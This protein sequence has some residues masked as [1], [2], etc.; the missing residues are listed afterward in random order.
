[1]KSHENW[2][3]FQS[4]NDP[5]FFCNWEDKFF[6]GSINANDIGYAIQFNQK[7]LI[8]LA[9]TNKESYKKL[10]KKSLM[11]YNETDFCWEYIIDLGIQEGMFR[12]VE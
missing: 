6:K 3:H 1:M 11:W 4:V 12:K 9:R 5:D 7:S 8:N 2:L 10:Y